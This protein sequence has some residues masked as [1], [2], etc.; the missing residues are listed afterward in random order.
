MRNVG[1]EIAENT[2]VYVALQADDESKVWD[3]IESDPVI[4]EPEEAYQFTAKGLRVPGGKS[5]RVYV[6]ASGEN[7]LSEEI[8]SEWVSI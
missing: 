7:L 6:Q 8:T 5:F 1:S 4:I 3:Q 2:T